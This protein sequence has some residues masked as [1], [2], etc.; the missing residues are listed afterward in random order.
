MT[1]LFRV[2]S[3]ASQPH[4]KGSPLPVLTPKGG[5]TNL[6]GGGGVNALEGGGRVNTVKTL[7][8]EK[9]G[10]LVHDPPPSSYSGAPAHVPSLPPSSFS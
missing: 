7:K 1:T 5:T 10:E 8:F 4:L 6:K 2:A 9:G 3:V